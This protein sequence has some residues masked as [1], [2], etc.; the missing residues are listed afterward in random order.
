MFTGILLIL[1]AGAAFS[2]KLA[3]DYVTVS[4]VND[5]GYT[6]VQLYAKPSRSAD[7]EDNKA[8][9]A[10]KDEA[11]LNLELFYND[12]DFKAVDEDGDIYI[13]KRVD[14]FKTKRIE[15]T[16]DDMED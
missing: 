8:K 12:W 4:V 3:D 14:L 1:A 6:I 11:S 13:I 5:T 7:W 10:I 16:E 2:Q 15:F 9:Q